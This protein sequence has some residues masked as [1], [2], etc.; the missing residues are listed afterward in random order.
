[1]SSLS[2]GLIV[3][4]FRTAPRLEHT[5][6]PFSPPTANSFFLC[7]DNDDDDDEDDGPQRE[8][9][10]KERKLSDIFPLMYSAV[11]ENLMHSSSWRSLSLS[12]FLCLCVCSN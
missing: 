7:L 1:M 8:E 10:S 4:L 9:K 12:L 5:Y 2:L 11:E 6:T 3:S